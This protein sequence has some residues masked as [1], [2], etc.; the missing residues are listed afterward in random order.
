MQI[1]DDD[2]AHAPVPLTVL[3]GFL[4]A[5][6]TTLLNRI[7]NGRHG[8]RV[9][10][11]VNDF[12][13]VNIDAE[14][15]VDVQGDVVS[16]ANGCVCCTIRDDLVAAVVETL[17]RPERPEFL[18]LEASGVAEPAGI[19]ATF[20]GDAVRDSIRLDAI[21][22][23]VDAE[24]LFAA[25]ETME[26]KLFQMACADMIVLNKVDLVDA[27]RIAAVR[28]FL[29]TRFHRYR[30]IE[31]SHANVPLE[32]LLSAGGFD[33]ARS[34]ADA[35]QGGY[36]HA[37][38]GQIH[39]AWRDHGVAFDTWMFTSALPSS[40]AAV[41]QAAASLPAGIYRAKGVIHAVDAHERRVV[42]QV[43]GR[44][45]ELT[46][47]GP[48]GERAPVTRIVGIGA[49]GAMTDEA[50]RTLF[51]QCVVPGKGGA[52]EDVRRPVAP[53]GAGLTGPGIY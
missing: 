43:V 16:L 6:K 50:F 3:T 8:L 51:A 47:A 49:R 25:P 37:T 40:L 48:W 1:P 35:A 31:A 22:C 46:Y 5:G 7:L 42:L 11:L 18:V 26:L 4:G 29:D 23:V 53:V 44:R 38:P 17:R 12:G 20:N 2:S 30:M 10:V 52:C 21:L 24:Q 14:L 9:G 36:V 28:A 39:D 45:V 32:I 15:V 19:A 34:G 27:G 33:A 13:S 41:R